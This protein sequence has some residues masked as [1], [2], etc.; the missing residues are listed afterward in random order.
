VARCCYCY[1]EGRRADVDTAT[2]GIDGTDGGDVLG[3]AE[4]ADASSDRRRGWIPRRGA[5]LG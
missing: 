5:G 4:S 2:G 1:S 3:F